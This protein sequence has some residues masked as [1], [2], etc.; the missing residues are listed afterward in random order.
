[1][2]KQNLK[3]IPS[4]S[5]HVAEQW[6]SLEGINHEP[7]CYTRVYTRLETRTKESGTIANYNN[8]NCNSVMKVRRS[9]TLRSFPRKRLVILLGP[10]RL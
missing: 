9:R 7:H 10:E 3:L 1:M 2:L 4:T 6:P 8:G 5:T